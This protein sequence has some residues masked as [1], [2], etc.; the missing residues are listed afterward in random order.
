VV[1]HQLA[2]PWCL[3]RS[4]R[5]GTAAR[6]AAD[7]GAQE[8]CCQYQSGLGSRTRTW[9]ARGVG[10]EIAG[11]DHEGVTGGGEQTIDEKARPDRMADAL[12]AAMNWPWHSAGAATAMAELYARNRRGERRVADGD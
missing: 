9:H 4:E 11:E 7:S 12:I 3:T 6:P 2:R 10:V 1:S 5:A 8:P